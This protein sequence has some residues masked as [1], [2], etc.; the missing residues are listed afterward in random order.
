MLIRSTGL[1]RVELD[2]TVENLTPNGDYL[3]MVFQ[4]HKPVKWRVRIAMSYSDMLHVLKLALKAK[5]LSFFLNVKRAFKQPAPP[6][7]Y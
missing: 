1:G 6:A 5:V 4:C 2:G 3:I 7:E